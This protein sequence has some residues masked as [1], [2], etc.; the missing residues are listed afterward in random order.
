MIFIYRQK[1]RRILQQES[2]EEGDAY[3]LSI[4]YS[5]VFIVSV[6]TQKDWSK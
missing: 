2:M 4:Q 5:V 6:Q 3:F 1:Y